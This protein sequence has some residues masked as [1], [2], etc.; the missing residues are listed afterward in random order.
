[1]EILQGLNW[2]G[3]AA[4]TVA[5]YVVG[6]IWYQPAVFGTRWMAAQPH[7]KAPE[8]YQNAVPGMFVQFLATLF[9]AILF[10]VVMGVLGALAT[11]LLLILVYAFGGA[12]AAIFE[13]HQRTLWLI[14]GGSAVASL[15]TIGLVL[16]W[17]QT[18]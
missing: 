6:A 14:N 12:A 4:A 11:G 7:R 16:S 17:A 13:G 10:A 3:I 1:M 5:A 2:W 9:T 18:W 8:D 15:V